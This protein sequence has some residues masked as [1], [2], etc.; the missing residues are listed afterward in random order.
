[1]TDV[2]TVSA[3]YIFLDIVGFTRNRSIEAQSDLV[4][5]LNGI[6][7]EAVKALAIP[8]KQLIFLPTGDGMCVCLLNV[9][10][11]YDCHMLLALNIIERVSRWNKKTS[12]AM[13]QFQIRTGL[14]AN[15]DNLV[16]D[17]NG[18][19]NLAG[20]GINIAQRVMTTGEGNQI[21]VGAVVYETL[22]EREKYMKQFRSYSVRV[23]HGT[24]LDVH[25]FVEPGHEGLDITIPSQ[26]IDQQVEEPSLTRMA[27]YYMAHALKLQELFA[28]N[29]GDIVAAHAGIVLLW[30][31]ARDSV[32]ADEVSQFEKREPRVWKAGSA[33]P[34]EQ[35]THYK[36]VDWVVRNQLVRFIESA[37]AV[38]SRYFE[39]T[40][41]CEY[42]FLNK[43]G[44]E[45]LKSEFPKIWNAFAPEPGND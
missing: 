30:L 2:R 19:D 29:S 40:L 1:M 14:N 41:L 7:S 6:V 36:E 31:L 3:K 32:R 15:V 20:A 10:S 44:K 18:R 34:E 23:K 33:S 5:A 39:S 13:R 35:L 28:T 26:F 11:P 22:R 12:D 43:A 24:E 42:H 8:E 9:D 27:A 38:Y 25:Q 45:K 37:L 21:M 4:A 16:T 17:I